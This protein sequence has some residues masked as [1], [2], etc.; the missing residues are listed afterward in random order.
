MKKVVLILLL[1]LSISCSKGESSQEK[2]YSITSAVTA[3]RDGA[4]LVDIR[5]E[6]ERQ[7][8]GFLKYS[9]HIPFEAI[10]DRMLE[11]GED[12][13]QSI[14]IYSGDDNDSKKAKK[15]LIES[16]YKNVISGISY[17]DLAKHLS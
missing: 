8:K 6:K 5:D 10:H 9:L 12:K 7:E 17:K 14:V 2:L 11:F 3:I 1:I 13:M 16:G 15:I 4:T